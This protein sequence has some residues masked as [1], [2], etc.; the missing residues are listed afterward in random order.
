MRSQYGESSPTYRTYRSLLPSEVIGENSV[1]S[2]QIPSS[3]LHGQGRSQRIYEIE[4]V[5]SSKEEDES[6]LILESD[7]ILIPRSEVSI[8]EDTHNVFENTG[9]IL[10]SQLIQRSVVPTS[11]SAN[12]LS[13][14]AQRIEKWCSLLIGEH[15]LLYEPFPPAARLSILVVSIWATASRQVWC[16]VFFDEVVIKQVSAPK[17]ITSALEV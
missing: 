12:V 11:R 7:S 9:D 4:Y 10:S 2:P 13:V 17:G 16:R 14:Q 3:Q 5:P 6:A 8:L 15:T 1:S